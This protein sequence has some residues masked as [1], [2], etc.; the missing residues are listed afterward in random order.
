VGDRHLEGM[1]NRSPITVLVLSLVTFGIYA[2]I[3]QV[4]TKNEMNE[5]FR[6]G[7]PTAWLILV[8]F[9]GALYWLWKWSEGAERASGMSQVS[10]FLLMVLIPVVG[11]PVLV[12]KFNEASAT[13]IATATL[14]AA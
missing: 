2:L 9:V 12:S 1:K 7:I 3:W 6:A 8:P 10:V 13:Q 11:I 5:K 4:Q 14:R